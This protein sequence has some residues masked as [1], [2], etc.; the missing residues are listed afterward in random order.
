[1]SLFA[2][3]VLTGIV[4]GTIHFIQESPTS[5]VIV[6]GEVKGLTK[7]LHGFHV[8][9]SGDMTNGCTSM[10]SHYNPYGKNHGG[11]SDT[12]RHVGDLGNIIAGADGIARVD[13]TDDLLSLSGKYS[14]LGRGLIVHADPDDLGRGGEHD[15]LTTGH[16][17]ARV[18]CGIIL[19][20][21]V[22]PSL[23]KRLMDTLAQIQK[24]KKMK[25][26]KEAMSEKKPLDALDWA[27]VIGI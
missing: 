16:A 19:E 11:P 1:M 13:I 2:V 25:K 12:E 5:P 7:G 6:R 8:H 21:T 17:G 14:I 3:A 15:S 9:Q 10:G 26:E 20:T 23:E 27:S 4:T 24:E 22:K 18:G